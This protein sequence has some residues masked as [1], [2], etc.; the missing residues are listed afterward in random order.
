L[1]RYVENE[2]AASRVKNNI[3]EQVMEKE[4]LIITWQLL[5]RAKKMEAFI[6]N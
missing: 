3:V 5:G 1:K 4:D 2:L 6:E